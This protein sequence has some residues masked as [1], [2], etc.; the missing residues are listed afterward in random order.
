MIGL[1]VVASALIG[2]G[3]NL[4]EYIL[5]IFLGFNVAFLFG[6]AG[7]A[8]NDYFDYENDKINHP[9]RPIPSGKLKPED[10]LGFS[11]FF[12]IL[13]YLLS[14]LLSSIVGYEALL[15]VTF[16]FVS[17]IAYEKKYK[18]EK[19]IGNLIIGTQTALAF[20]FGG[21]IVGK[22]VITSIIAI[23]VFFSIVGREM[24]KDIEDIRGDKDRVTLP[25]KIG[26]KKAGVV[27]AIFILLAVLISPLPYYPFHQFGWEYLLVVSIADIL[28]IC[29]IP[30]IFH[31]AKLAR[32]MLKSAML[33]AIFAFVAGALFKV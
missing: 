8:L 1:V 22:T 16:A 7:N 32:R 28:F 14:L 33:I 21:I 13:S 3:S 25:M 12:F 20:V 23:A 2:V 15:I 27:A 31:N 24:V 26:V 5:P 18:H 19:I 11:I 6:I 17:Q 29:S 9:D 4:N 10:V 30:M